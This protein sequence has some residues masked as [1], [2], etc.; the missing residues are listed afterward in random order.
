MDYM[1]KLIE[2]EDIIKAAKLNKFGGA[3]A[4]RVLMLLL[5]I[6]KINKLYAEI[7]HK[8]G[9]DFIDTLIDELKL[10]FEVSEEELNGFPGQGRSSPFQII[11]LEVSTECSW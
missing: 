10:N 11:L 5:R 1:K 4:A 2:T 8:Q 7:S 9:I 3:S 6:N